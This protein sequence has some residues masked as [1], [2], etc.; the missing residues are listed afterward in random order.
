M[1]MPSEWEERAPDRPHSEYLDEASFSP[2]TTTYRLAHSSCLRFPS[3]PLLPI[4]ALLPHPNLAST[5]RRTAHGT[6]RKRAFT[7]EDL[8]REEARFK[9]VTALSS[10]TYSILGSCS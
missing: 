6:H 1:R 3:S 10:S 7:P 5:W 2:W 4:A 9:L 8:V